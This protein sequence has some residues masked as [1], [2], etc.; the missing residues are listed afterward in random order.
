MTRLGPLL[1]L[2]L[3][4]GA[5]GPAP[6]APSPSATLFLPGTW[7]GIMSV[8]LNGLPAVTGPTTWRFQSV[9]ETDG[10]TYRA[11]IQS[12]NPSLSISTTGSTALTPPS[13]A[14]AQI[15]TQ[16]DYLSPRGCRGT[17][18]SFGVVDEHHLTATF[19]GVDCDQ[20]FYGSVELS[21]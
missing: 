6:T 21:R 8:S 18:G 9:P 1:V 12:L 3:A 5:C 20:T 7:S 19:E 10:S 16:G 17:F 2:V 4:S 14:P 11:I 13:T 15:A